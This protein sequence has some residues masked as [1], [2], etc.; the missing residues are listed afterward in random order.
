[1][2]KWCTFVAAHHQYH[3]RCIN[4]GYLNFFFRLRFS[5]TLFVSCWNFFFHSHFIRFFCT[6]RELPVTSP[7]HPRYTCIC[8]II[9]IKMP[10]L[11][12]ALY[13]FLLGI[14]TFNQL[15][16]LLAIH[17]SSTLVISLTVFYVIIL[18]IIF[19]C[20][21][22]NSHPFPPFVPTRIC[23]PDTIQICGE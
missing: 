6:S 17:P 12:S 21:K 20:S 23:N 2:S 4:E 8:S 22:K 13:S 3:S 9:T 16:W 14:H 5:N 10:P 1:M 18:A 15:L 11:C 19:F 7:F